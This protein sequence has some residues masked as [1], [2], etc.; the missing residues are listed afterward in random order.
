MKSFH[1][2]FLIIFV[3]CSFFL[4]DLS[5][6]SPDPANVFSRGTTAR[7]RSREAKEAKRE[8]DAAALNA[9]RPIVLDTSGGA[10]LVDPKYG[11]TNLGV[12]GMWFERLQNHDFAYWHLQ[13]LFWEN[14]VFK[15]VAMKSGSNIV[16]LAFGKNDDGEQ[17]QVMQFRNDY[18]HDKDHN[19]IS[20]PEPVWGERFLTTLD[21]G[22]LLGKGGADNSMDV[23]SDKH[24]WHTRQ[25]PQDGYGQFVAHTKR[26]R[27]PEDGNQTYDN[28][29]W[30][31]D[32]AI[33]DNKVWFLSA[34]GEHNKT[35]GHEFKIFVDTGQTAGI[36]PSHNYGDGLIVG[37]LNNKKPERIS[38]GDDGV[39][40]AIDEDGKLYK[41]N[42][43]RV[44][45]SSWTAV[46]MPDGV[47]ALSDIDIGSR[48]DRRIVALDV[49]K[50]PHLLFDFES[51]I[52]V[53][54]RL[55]SASV[56]IGSDGVFAI[57]P[58]GFGPIY[59]I[60]IDDLLLRSPH[61]KP[62][63]GL[64][65]EV[66]SGDRF[67]IRNVNG[68]VMWV[69]DAGFVN[70]DKHNPSDPRALFEY[71]EI[72]NKVWTFSIKAY[73]GKY[74]EC[75]GRKPGEMAGA[76]KIGARLIATGSSSSSEKTQF[77][78]TPKGG[79][80]YFRSIETNGYLTRGTGNDAYLRSVD[81]A[82]NFEPFRALS[83][84]FW[85]IK[86]G[87]FIKQLGA[88]SDWWSVDTKHEN[89]AAYYEKVM[90]TDPLSFSWDKKLPGAETV[91]I[92]FPVA[93]HKYTLAYSLIKSIDQWADS[94]KAPESPEIVKALQENIVSELRTAFI[95]TELVP[96]ITSLDN[97]LATL[98]KVAPGDFNQSLAALKG[99][100]TNIG[101][102]DAR[103]TA[104]LENVR[105]FVADRVDGEGNIAPK[106]TFEDARSWMLGVV[107]GQNSL[108]VSK[109]GVQELLDQLAKPISAVE[110]LERLERFVELRSLDTA[111][112]ALFL[113]QIN[114]LVVS[115][116]PVGELSVADFIKVKAV[117]DKAKNRHTITVPT[118]IQTA[119][120]GERGFE[121]LIDYVR[122]IVN[123]HDD[124][125]GLW[126]VSLDY[127]N[128]SAPAYTMSRLWNL[129]KRWKEWQPVMERSEHM[130]PIKVIFAQVAASMEKPQMLAS[131]QNKNNAAEHTRI[132]AEV[133]AA[134][135]EVTAALAT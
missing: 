36:P 55:P 8:R 132:K 3:F 129:L 9:T 38:C 19:R 109:G 66:V 20:G 58:D 126:D 89:A 119:F 108:V 11:F 134:L 124:G 12:K 31:S 42:G 25:L 77:M 122:K 131:F 95:G 133:Q 94:E 39:P 30:V 63:S 44:G 78:V 101:A 48:A 4:F 110:R 45:H 92:N 82:N 80:F 117:M 104:F 127:G 83:T 5:P 67:V 15:K 43:S 18:R 51:E 116:V 37:N 81:P 33:G 56:A 60:N 17:H 46:T 76:S 71:E 1:T 135:T 50:V 106:T 74:L 16:G 90:Q 88:V 114:K 118:E 70:F 102:D 128:A 100:F 6:S 97:K 123:A 47:T 65:D 98:L 57:V 75:R 14:F 32:I 62:M 87:T 10:E 120:D 68:D 27:E 130:T 23:R 22:A 85:F 54:L 72:A 93:T 91:L 13:S 52:W 34:G 29:D 2:K 113:K 28:V 53:T 125:S 69:D 84:E 112:K 115:G 26:S 99:M 96:L 40:W 105:S 35:Q 64:P 24:I 59:T 103:A 111:Q 73:N 21:Q 86:V 121:S 7:R 107:L 79:N 41:D 61:F 49:N